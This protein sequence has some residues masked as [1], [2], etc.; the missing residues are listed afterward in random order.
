M[1]KLFDILP[2]QVIAVD[3]NGSV[4][5][6]ATQ[7]G[8]VPG[9]NGGRISNSGADTSAIVFAENVKGIGSRG[10][11]GLGQAGAFLIQNAGYDAISPI[12]NAKDAIVNGEGTLTNGFTLTY[13]DGSQLKAN[14]VLKDA[15][16]TNLNKV[17]DLGFSRGTLLPP[18]TKPDYHADIDEVGGHIVHISA[19]DNPGWNVPTAFGN[20]KTL[21]VAVRD[22]FR[23]WLMWRFPESGEQGPTIYPLAS[24]DWDAFF[25]AGGNLAQNAV[26]STISVTAAAKVTVNP[27]VVNH[28]TPGVLVPPVFNDIFTVENKQ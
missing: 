4:S 6:V 27:Y 21:D 9:P 5:I 8:F 17:L 18:N 22:N 26:A 25:R 1:I 2:G 7:K 10:H 19:E 24:I 16:G 23:I 20:G 15:N 3:N 13:N 14:G 11:V 12:G 28:T